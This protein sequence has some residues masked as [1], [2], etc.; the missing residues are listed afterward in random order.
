[1]EQ[2]CRSDF[3]K[4]ASM[5]FCCVF[6]CCMDETLGTCVFEMTP[7]VWQISDLELLNILLRDSLLLYSF[8]ELPV[9][10]GRMSH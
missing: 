2:Q 8:F 6:L 4:K 7:A 3:S 1:M 9:F 5:M 10:R